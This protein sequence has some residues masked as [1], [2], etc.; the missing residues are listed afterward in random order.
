MT[1]IAILGAGKLFGPE[2]RG[3]EIE[4]AYRED[5]AALA[6]QQRRVGRN[7]AIRAAFRYAF[8]ISATGAPVDSI[9]IG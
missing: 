2:H 8:V 3:A 7:R 6:A 9:T 5:P 1:R 4:R